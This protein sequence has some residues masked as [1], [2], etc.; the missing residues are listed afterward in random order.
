[1]AVYKRAYKPYTGSLTPT[2]SR[3]LILPRYAFRTVFRSKILT[4][5]FVL[6]FVPFIVS[7]AIIYLYN[8]PIARTLIGMREDQNFPFS[9]GGRFFYYLLRIQAG[10]AFLLNIWVGPTLVSPDLVNNALP[11]YLS[12]PFSRTEYVIGKMS[13]LFM[14]L[15]GI[16][17]IPDLLL[18]GIQAT[19]AGG[20]WF[21]SHLDLAGAIVASSLIWI[22]LMSLLSLAM[23][24]WVKWRIAASGLLFGFFVVTAG[25]GAIFNEVVRTYWGKVLNIDYV[26]SVIWQ[27]LFN[28]STVTGISRR[29]VGTFREQDVPVGIAW[30][31]LAA[32]CSAAL[33]MLNKRLRAR[34]VVRG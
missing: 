20:G 17:L 8:N 1:M 2:W 31:V 24:A 30:L 4:G 16:T 25:F 32:L 34:E 14:L 27:D 6:C 26:F 18:Y 9:I 21:M 5:Y 13:V 33:F 19:L 29:W 22:A 10:M 11:L 12:R 15:G 23:S 28:V 7:L 3:F